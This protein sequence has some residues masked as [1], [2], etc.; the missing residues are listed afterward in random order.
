MPV[1]LGLR[2][3]RPGLLLGAMGAN[4]AG[5]L[6]ALLGWL[7]PASFLLLIGCIG[8]A[9]AIRLFEPSDKSPKVAGVH[10]SFPLFVRLGYVWLH[11]AAMLAVWA[12]FV[13]SNNSG[14]LGSSRHALTVGFVA[15]MVFSVG[16]R[17][18]PAFCGMHLLA[19]PRMM[20]AS[21]AL[22]MTGCAMRVGTEILAYQNYA[23]WAWSVLPLSAIIE[24][25]AVTLFAVN[26]VW[27][28]MRRPAVARSPLTQFTE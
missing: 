24:M 9:N 8:A 23:D 1:F 7:Q 4:T 26:L 15:A 5:V 21:L 3:L 19:S 28:F 13:G 10:A 12:Q 16:Q 22:L 27:S 2:P 6:A 14:I 25:T 20:L 11:V 17:V 18:L